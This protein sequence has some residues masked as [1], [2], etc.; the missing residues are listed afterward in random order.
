MVVKLKRRVLHIIHDLKLKLTL[1]N[2][3]NHLQSEFNIVFI[4]LL[5]LAVIISRNSYTSLLKSLQLLLTYHFYK[6][7]CNENHH[8][9]PY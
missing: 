2:Y 1:V 5:T 4:H 6:S 8:R 3:C 9:Q 7:V